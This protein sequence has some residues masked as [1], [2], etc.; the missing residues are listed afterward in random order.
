MHYIFI[1]NRTL[2]R[3]S[4]YAELLLIDGRHAVEFPHLKRTGLVGVGATLAGLALLGDASL[5]RVYWL[6]GT[7]GTLPLA[8]L[9]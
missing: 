4:S 3:Q 5:A 2:G 6:L 7:V 9:V 1:N 8:G